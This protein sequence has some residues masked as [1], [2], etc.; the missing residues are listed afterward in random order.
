MVFGETMWS[1]ATLKFYMRVPK[2]F[3]PIS[4]LLVIFGLGTYYPKKQCN[5]I[6]KCEHCILWPKNLKFSLR[7][8]G[9]WSS[10]AFS[11]PMACVKMRWLKTLLLCRG[12]I[13]SFCD[14]YNCSICNI[15]FAITIGIK[16]A[17]VQ[18]TSIFYSDLHVFYCHIKLQS[19]Q[20]YLMLA[21][22]LTSKLKGRP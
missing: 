18:H 17:C 16:E 11:Y 9:D 1:K 7:P 15:S 14:F 19:D 20:K 22:T 2:V 3:G 12:A 6:Y 10:D 8:L 5:R 21:D 4:D 13:I